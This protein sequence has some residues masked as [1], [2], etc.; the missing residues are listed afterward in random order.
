MFQCEENRILLP[1]S[2]SEALDVCH[3]VSDDVEVLSLPADKQ[4]ARLLAWAAAEVAE[5]V[6]H[7]VAGLDRDFGQHSRS[8]LVYIY[9]PPR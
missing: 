9:I 3:S 7:R 8:Q 4:K 2:A 5:R 1:L 6:Q